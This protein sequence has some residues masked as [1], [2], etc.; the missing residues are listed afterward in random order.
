MSTKLHNTLYFTSD[1]LVT[2]VRHTQ[3]NNTATNGWLDHCVARDALG[4]AEPT[5]GTVNL[6]AT[7][8]AFGNDHAFGDSAL[9]RKESG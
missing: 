7:A 8:L 6:R 4:I 1:I 3:F 5:I 9:R 2:E